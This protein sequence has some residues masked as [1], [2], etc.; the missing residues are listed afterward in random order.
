MG[1]CF[2]GDRSGSPAGPEHSSMLG[3]QPQWLRGTES[4]RGPKEL[5][6]PLSQRLL[7]K[8][9]G[10]TPSVILIL[11]TGKIAPCVRVSDRYRAAQSLQIPLVLVSSVARMSQLTWGWSEGGGLELRVPDTVAAGYCKDCSLQCS[12][13]RKNLPHSV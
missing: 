12:G 8:L 1:C 7:S 13:V 9:I 2:V 11:A 3:S 4:G 10:S 5:L 6:L